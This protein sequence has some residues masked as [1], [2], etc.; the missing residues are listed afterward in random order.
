MHRE[1][2]QVA[3]PGDRVLFEGR[4]AGFLEQSVAKQLRFAG[5]LLSAGTLP[6]TL[7]KALSGAQP[8]EFRLYASDGG[9]QHYVLRV[10]ERVPA[11]TKPYTDVREPLGREIEADKVG[12]A[13]RDYAAKL[14]KVQKIDV[15]I[16]RIAG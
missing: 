4:G 1:P 9:A 3:A 2:E 7:V 16:T 6:A 12:A 5:A 10:V 14:R 11:G 8:N 13:V 15:L